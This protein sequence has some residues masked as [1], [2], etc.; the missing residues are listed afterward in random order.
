MLDKERAEKKQQFLLKEERKVLAKRHV[1]ETEE[2]NEKL[3]L[4]MELARMRSERVK[5]ELQRKS[6][7]GQKKKKLLEKQRRVSF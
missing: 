3:R 7:V 6:E 5:S 4:L 2:R 1:I